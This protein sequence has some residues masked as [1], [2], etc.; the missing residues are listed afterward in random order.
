MECGA[1]APLDAHCYVG[2]PCRAASPLPEEQA[3][4]AFEK[5]DRLLPEPTGG[6][7]AAGSDRSFRATQKLGWVLRRGQGVA[8]GHAAAR[9]ST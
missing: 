6:S 8:A 1:S 3:M 7:P 2:I 5:R 4:L 9:K